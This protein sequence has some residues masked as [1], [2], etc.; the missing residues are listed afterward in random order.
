MRQP[1]P[2]DAGTAEVLAFVRRA[3]PAPPLRVVE[4]GC[5]RGELAAALQ[6]AGYEVT[7]LDADPDAVAAARAAGVP[8]RHADFLDGD[9]ERHDAVLFTRSLHH[10][11]SL[12]RAVAL[13]AEAGPI[14]IVDEFARERADAATAAWFSDARALL[15]ATGVLTPPHA[16]PLDPD[17]LQRWLVEYGDRREHRLH[18]GAEMEAALRTRLDV[19][20]VEAC[21]YLYRHLAQW[22]EVSERGAAVARLLL[23]LERARIARGE[24]VPLGVRAIARRRDAIE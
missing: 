21:P 1:S 17:P 6:A 9:A 10:I 7:A 3:L 19:V 13:A 11:A 4:V 8:A 14:V 5:G 15:A 24:L 22:L 16:D 12:D 2:L 23:E 18:T 20:S